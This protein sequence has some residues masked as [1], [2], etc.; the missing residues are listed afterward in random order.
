[1]NS[2][3]WQ[4]PPIPRVMLWGR[5]SPIKEIEMNINLYIDAVLKIKSQ[6]D[7]YDG[8]NK[9]IATAQHDNDFYSRINPMD[10]YLKQAFVDVLNDA[11]FSLTGFS[12]LA[13]YYLYERPTGAEIIDVDDGRTYTWNNGEEFKQTVIQMIKDKG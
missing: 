13:S 1:M 5:C 9:Q 11:L 10:N 4:K 7:I 6:I 3:A 8:I 12:E 2:A